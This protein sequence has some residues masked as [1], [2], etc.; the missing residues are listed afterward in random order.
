MCARNAAWQR[1]QAQ[2]RQTPARARSERIAALFAAAMQQQREDRPPKQH[3]ATYDYT[4]ENGEL[5]YQ[6]LK[7]E[8]PKDVRA[9]PA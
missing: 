7:Y 1:L 2:R 8:S 9:T 6:V 5:L 3:V 4:D